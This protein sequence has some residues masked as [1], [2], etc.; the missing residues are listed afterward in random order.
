[1]RS[2]AKTGKPRPRFYL[3]VALALAAM[4]SLIVLRHLKG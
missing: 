3:S 4:G 1:M 2:D